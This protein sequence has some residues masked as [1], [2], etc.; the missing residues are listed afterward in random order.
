MS[1]R[2][3]IQ[4]IIR[5][6]L[7]RQYRRTNPKGSELLEVAYDLR[8]YFGLYKSFLGGFKKFDGYWNDLDITIQYNTSGDSLQVFVSPKFNPPTGSN[9]V[10]IDFTST[11]KYKAREKGGDSLGSFSYD[12]PSK[13]GE[14]IKSLVKKLDENQLTEQSDVETATGIAQMAHAGQYRRSSGKPYIVHPIRVKQLAKQFGYGKDVQITAILHDVLEDA[15]NEKFYRREI[16]RRFDD[17][18]LNAVEA[19]THEKSESYDTYLMDLARSNDLAFK[20]KMMDMASNLMTSPTRSQLEKYRNVIETLRD[21]GIEV[22]DKIITLLR[23]KN[24]NKNMR[25]TKSKLKE[26]IREMMNEEYSD[27]SKISG[28]RKISKIEGVPEEFIVVEYPS[29][30]DTVYENV[31]QTDYQGLMEIG[32]GS[33]KPPQIFGVY[34]V[35]DKDQALQDAQ[36]LM[37]EN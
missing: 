25:L 13:F 12:T 32:R 2:S 15:P 33:S 23:M 28:S 17:R 26:I 30:N 18:I 8:E 7:E 10:E 6:E 34:H 31:Y 3:K 11:S 21:R 35:S 14:K 16:K 9:V 22:P 5:E 27:L 36:N 37:M 1:F 24:E 20:V 19:L 29:P 4:H